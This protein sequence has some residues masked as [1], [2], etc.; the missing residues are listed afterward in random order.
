MRNFFSLRKTL[1]SVALA[2]LCALAS[3]TAGMAAGSSLFDR[4]YNVIP[5]PQQVSFKGGDF[6]L[7]SGWRRS[8]SF[9]TSARASVWP[10]L[11]LNCAVPETC[12]ASSSTA[13]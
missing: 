9:Q 1:F 13:T 3:A 5:V 7:G 8:R 11:T 2:A 4:G 6:E 12:W 10:R